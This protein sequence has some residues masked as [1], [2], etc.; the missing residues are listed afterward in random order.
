MD[1]SL[2]N[3]IIFLDTDNENISA[4]TAILPDGSHAPMT[5]NNIKAIAQGLDRGSIS[6]VIVSMPQPPDEGFE[7]PIDMA[8]YADNCNDFMKIVYQ[9][10]LLPDDIFGTDTQLNTVTGTVI[11]YKTAP[12]V[13]DPTEQHSVMLISQNY[14]PVSPQ[15]NLIKAA[16]PQ[17]P[18]IDESKTLP[19]LPEKERFNAAKAAERILKKV[20]IVQHNNAVYVYQGTY[21]QLFDTPKLYKLIRNTLYKETN[22]NGTSG[23]IKDISRFI[24]TDAKIVDFDNA[25]IRN[26]VMFTNYVFNLDSFSTELHSPSNYNTHALSVPFVS[27]ADSDMPIFNKYIYDLANGDPLLIR[28]IWE[29]LG[30]LLCS[31]TKAKRIV[32]LV[33]DGDTG[34]SVF[35]KIVTELIADKNVTSF[36]PQRLTDRFVGTSLVNSAVN[37]CMDLPSTPIDAATAAIL[38]NLS[39]GDMVSGEIKYMNS[40]AYVYQGQLLFGTNYPLQLAYR[41]QAFANRLLIVPCLNPI[42]KN[43]QDKNLAEHIRP[44][45]A[46]IASRAVRA[47]A[48]VRKNG[49]IFAGDDIYSVSAEDIYVKSS[50]NVTVNNSKDYSVERFAYQMCKITANNEDFIPAAEL[51]R[52]YCVFCQ[53]NGMEAISDT[54]TF[55]KELHKALPDITNK[56]KRVDGKSVNVWCCINL[57]TE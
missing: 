43:L 28:R 37:I 27:Y 56:K 14:I 49:Y 33:G 18:N 5:E 51:Y 17:Q 3:P 26:K 39:G 38:K 15:I 30:L 9:N 24:Q 6:K 48:F 21:Y 46:M 50:I 25:N 8:E 19:T 2:K 53:R 1:K 16:E 4:A 54:N 52:H 31:D 44:E 47:F 40:F 20:T 10:S 22:L 35:G 42:P 29:V 32:V 36:T 7:S 57:R 34:K 45:L 23:Y 41:D 55:S 13:Y 12:A 11:D